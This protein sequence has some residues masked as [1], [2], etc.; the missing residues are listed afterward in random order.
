MEKIQ[1]IFF[2]IDKTVRILIVVGI[3][4]L[5]LVGFYFL[6]ISDMLAE[7]SRLEGEINKTNVDIARQE[8]IKKEGPK[9]EQQIKEYEKQLLALVGSLPERQEIEGLLKRITDLLSETN[10]VAKRFIPGQEQINEDLYYAKIPLSL[11]V[12]GSF[13]Q[14]G[15]FFAGLNGLPRIVNVP[16]VRFGKAGGLSGREDELARKL[17]II[18]LD[19][20]IAAETYRR[21]SQDEI[22]A[23][24]A[25]KKAPGRPPR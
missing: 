4:L 17:S 24:Q 12:R 16:S 10:L 9:L 7:I 15:A 8:E 20:E 22:K 13:A 25:K 14:Q 5:L 21:L 11:S 23:I 1:E 2:R 6:W 18:S 3:C 19:T